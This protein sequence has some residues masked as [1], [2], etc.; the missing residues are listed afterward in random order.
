MSVASMQRLMTEQAIS[1]TK[2]R[3]KFPGRP[4]YNTIVGWSVR[5]CRNRHTGSRVHLE[6]MRVGDGI[7]T[8]EEAIQ[9]FL[10]RL[11]TE[12]ETGEEECP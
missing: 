8:S 11:N 2:A 10:V 1:L 6:T 3:D 5:G 4:H 7:F 12:E 9:R